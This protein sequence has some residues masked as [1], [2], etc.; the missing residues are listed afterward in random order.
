MGMGIFP[1]GQE[2]GKGIFIEGDVLLGGD[3]VDE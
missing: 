2:G 1:D 3:K